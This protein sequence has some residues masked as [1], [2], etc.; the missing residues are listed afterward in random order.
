MNTSSNKK[1]Y[2]DIIDNDVKKE[3]EFL[4]NNSLNDISNKDIK[5]ELKKINNNI[6]Y[7]HLLSDKIQEQINED[8]EDAFTTDSEFDSDLDSDLDSNSKNDKL[9]KKRKKKT[10]IKEG[11]NIKEE[12]NIDHN[13]LNEDLLLD[14]SSD[15]SD[16]DSDLD[17]ELDSEISDI[18]D[19]DMSD[20]DTSS[21]NDYQL[22]D[23]ENNKDFTDTIIKGGS[24]EE[25]TKKKEFIEELV[26]NN[27]VYFITDKHNKNYY[28]DFKNLKVNK[29]KICDENNIFLK[30]TKLNTMVTQDGT[31]LKA[32]KTRNYDIYRIKLL[33]EITIEL[34]GKYMN[35]STRI[36]ELKFESGPPTPSPS[37]SPASASAPPP[38]P[39]PP[40]PPLLHLPLLESVAILEKNKK[41]KISI[42]TLPSFLKKKD[43]IAII[44]EKSDEV[45]ILELTKKAAKKEKG[46]K[47]ADKKEAKNGKIADNNEH[48]Y[49][50]MNHNKDIAIL[51]EKQVED[52]DDEYEPVVR[53]N[54]AILETEDESYGHMEHNKSIAILEEKQ[55]EDEDYEYEPVVRSNIAILE[56]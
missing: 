35:N 49:E 4:Q 3:I 51:E 47:K 50:N 9:K 16:L 55:V 40:P 27:K 17:S 36:K 8:E 18:S 44:E 42:P 54:I 10:Y 30:D 26:K 56:T 38:P 21:N 23:S 6:Y 53:S 15:D 14:V 31:Y 2:W 13:I 52:G 34:K 24:F 45:A 19:T 46:K 7:D 25:E 11:G 48:H 1:K 28:N 5:I 39:P 37:P 32:G 12:E 20:N 33:P 29:S 22:S 43:K 41:S